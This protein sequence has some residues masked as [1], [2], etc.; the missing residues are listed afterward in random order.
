M[1][2]RNVS[3]FARLS[4]FL[5]VILPLGGCGLD[6][7]LKHK[8]PPAPIEYTLSSPYSNP[9]TLAIAPVI[10]LSGSRNFDPLTVSDSIFA[11]MQQVGGLNV[12]PV[13]K[14]LMAMQR[15]GLRAIDTPEQA[16]AVARQMG[17]DAIVVPAVTAYDPY[18]PPVMGMT[19]HLYTARNLTPRVTAQA[20]RIDG[21]VTDAVESAPVD[22]RQPV[23]QVSAIFNAR[24]QTVLRELRGFASGRTEYASAMKDEK[25]LVDMDQYTRFVSHAMIRR[26]LELERNRVADR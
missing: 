15:L 17:A 2:E 9:T 23:S 12:M 3:V 7:S 22:T 5:L 24:N 26:L 8:T 11:E 19:L 14:T 10:N 18:D 4:L 13:N 20:R 16:Q 25:F 1:E 6:I 21:S